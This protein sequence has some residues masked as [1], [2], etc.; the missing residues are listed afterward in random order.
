[1][2]RWGVR[3]Q[4]SKVKRQRSKVK[5]QRSKVKGQRSK[6]KGQ[7]GGVAIVS[8][9]PTLPLPVSPTPS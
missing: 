6:V 9:S 4:T 3:S 8:L 5:R 7:E 2:G 1:M